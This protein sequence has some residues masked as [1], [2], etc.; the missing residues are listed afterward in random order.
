MFKT[1]DFVVHKADGLCRICDISTLSLD[2]F[3]DTQYYFLEPIYS[4]S[5][6]VYVAVGQ[7]ENTMREPIT[8]KEAEKLIDSIPDISELSIENEKLRQNAYSQ[9]LV[10]NDCQELFRLIKTTY[11]RKAERI[12]KGRTATTVD[13]HFLKSAENALYSE[14]SYVLGIDADNVVGY[15]EEKLERSV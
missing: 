13:E 12:A 15:I 11:Y 4:P 2:S 8:R 14:L 6:K 9:A 1:G 7:G 5:S 3:D 10:K